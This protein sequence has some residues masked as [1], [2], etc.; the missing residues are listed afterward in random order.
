MNPVPAE[1]PDGPFTRRQALAAGVTPT[2]LK[3]ARFVRVLPRV[4]R[5]V[6]HEMTDHDWVVAARLSLPP[7]C[8]LTG[9]SRLQQL[10][11]DYGPRR[12]LHFVRQGE[13][14]LDI[15]GIFLHRT[16]L[17]A[18][19]DG[20]GVTPA[21]AYLFYC[22]RARIIDAIKVGDWLLHHGHLTKDELGELALSATWRDGAHE[23]IWILEHLC[24]RSRSLKESETRAVI[25]FAG[26]PVPESNVPLD[27]DDGADLIGDLL[28]LP[29]GLLIEYEGR[30]H[31]LDRTQYSTDL[32]RYA[33][34]R[35]AGVRYVQVTNE[36]LTLARTLIG[37]IFRE[38][39]VLG[40]DGPPPEFGPHWR[41]LFRPVR[42]VVGSRN[43]WLRAWGRGA[44]S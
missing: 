4:W 21:G 15:E 43:E 16:K 10:G 40:Y 38:L 22:S 14:H 30:H 8:Q 2:M 1:L 25:A 17:L 27:V 37:E 9:L 36:K 24:H 41:S 42:E 39:L 26:L 35:R 28:I 33:A 31:Q 18:P 29:W 11:L 44:V 19:T 7:G 34:L 5:H 20:E 3:G 6:D 32:A 13:L 12:P 23:A